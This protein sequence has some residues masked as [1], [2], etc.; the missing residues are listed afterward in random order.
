MFDEAL[1][2]MCGFSTPFSNERSGRMDNTE[3]ARECG[4]KQSVLSSVV[5]FFLVLHVLSVV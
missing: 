1:D 4:C 5:S 3:I 2:D